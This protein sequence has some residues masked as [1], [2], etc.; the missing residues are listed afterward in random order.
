MEIEV[1]RRLHDALGRAD[2][3][4]QRG[5]FL[6]K[7]QGPL[8]KPDTTYKTRASAEKAV[9]RFQED[10]L[11]HLQKAAKLSR[12]WEE[13]AEKTPAEFE[14]FMTGVKKDL[15][16][17]M[18]DDDALLRRQARMILGK[19]RV[20]ESDLAGI[21]DERLTESLTFPQLYLEVVKPDRI[22]ELSTLGSAAAMDKV[23][24]EGEDTG[25]APLKAA[26]MEAQLEQ[27]EQLAEL[28]TLAKAK[29]RTTYQ[30]RKRLKEE[31]DTAKGARI[32]KIEKVGGLERVVY[33]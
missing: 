32:M 16:K 2:I 13:L 25:R 6:V 24:A 7:F 22:R 23:V 5:E 30:R 9:L 33:K 1:T 21:T 10:S 26:T 27:Q 15:V 4:E 17:R 31:I 11:K 3:I 14:K 19:G 8:L 12:K 20:S 28:R 29:I 18:R